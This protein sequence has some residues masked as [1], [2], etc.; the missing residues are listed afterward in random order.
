MEALGRIVS[1]GIGCALPDFYGV[2]TRVAVVSAWVS[3]V[4]GAG[5]P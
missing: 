4:I 5:A 3:E 2:Y 1:W